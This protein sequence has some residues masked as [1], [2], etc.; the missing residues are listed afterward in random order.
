MKSFTRLGFYLLHP[1]WIPFGASLFYFMI[2]PRYIPD[3][4]VKA[5]LLGIATLSIAIPSIFLSTLLKIN[6]AESIE[7]R[8]PKAKRLFLLC[9]C[10][11]IITIN[12]FVIQVNLPEL[13]F[14]FTAYLISLSL[15]LLLSLFKFNVSLHSLAMSALVTY[16]I[17]ISL[18][19]RIN[20]V[21]WIAA[22]IFLIG[23]AASSRIGKNA[24]RSSEVWIGLLIGAIP[25]LYFLYV[26]LQ[27]YK[28]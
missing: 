21:Y 19:Y 6:F 16:I 26:A 22:G 4:F 11:L 3:N 2:S 7:L 17:S 1:L 15:C 8:E 28:M 18:L 14:F 9:L 10:I 13:L 25:Q 5:K 27:H 12:N 24:H 20:L 23:W